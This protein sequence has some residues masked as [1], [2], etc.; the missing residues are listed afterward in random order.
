M[1]LYGGRAV[2][3]RGPAHAKTTRK[4]DLAEHVEETKKRSV[5]LQQMET[6]EEQKGWRVE[7]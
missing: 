3:A 2:H 1:N 7:R 5:L 4:K 6:E